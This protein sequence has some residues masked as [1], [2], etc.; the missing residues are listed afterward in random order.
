MSM[1]VLDHVCKSYP[2]AV[3]AGVQVLKDV[4]LRV[5][6]GQSV[7]IVGPSGSGKSTLL[8][9]IGTLDRPTSGALILEDQDLLALKE[10]ELAAIRNRKIGFVFQ[11]HHLLPQCSVLEN[12]LV[13]SLVN[14][15]S[16]G[17]ERRA[18]ELLEEVGL[19]GRLDH[20]PG[21]LSGGEQQRVAVVRA[22]INRPGL[23]I[24]DEPTGS[25]DRAGAENIADLLVRMNRQHAV[26]LVVVTHSMSLAR[27]MGTVHELVDGR[28]AVAP[29]R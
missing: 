15:E 14:A 17:A 2:S 23:L 5:D 20:R 29:V 4:N 21:Q 9:I 18:R 27:R 24:A 16:A 19:S 22:M 25:L 7:A 28:L 13:P 3:G 1:L 11:L 26:T 8:N 10:N 12:V 6:A